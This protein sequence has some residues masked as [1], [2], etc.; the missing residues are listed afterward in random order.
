MSLPSY[1]KFYNKDDKL[2]GTQFINAG[3]VMTTEGLVSSLLELA[4]FY[5]T[6]YVMAYSYKIPAKMIEDVRNPETGEWKDRKEL[7][8]SQIREIMERVDRA[9]RERQSNERP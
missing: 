8:T 7:F 4:Q 3:W 5:E 2:L 6:D 9:Y 1:A